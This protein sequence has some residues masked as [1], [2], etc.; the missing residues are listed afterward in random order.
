MTRRGP[1]R[2]EFA[3]PKQARTR[4]QLSRIL[5][6]T[7]HLFA[8]RGYE[9]TKIEDIAAAVPCSISTIYDR[10]G[11]KAELLRYM[12]R[13]GVEEAITLIGAMDPGEMEGDLRE[14][15]PQ[16]VR[17]GLAIMQRYRGRRRASAERMHADPELAALEL[18]IQEGL[19]AAGQGLLLAYRRQFDHPEPEL[20]ALHAM[21]MLMAM[22]EQRGGMLPTPEW[23]VLPEDRF[24]EEVTRM[25]LRYLGIS[26]TP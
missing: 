24:V 13:Q 4:E 23:A 20:A 3:E 14:S 5:E 25:V 15:L 16:A 6:E 17:M 8:E 7:D 18:D 9:A 2:G 1:K 22:T 12:H 21:R 19:I 26:Q 10:F 11:G